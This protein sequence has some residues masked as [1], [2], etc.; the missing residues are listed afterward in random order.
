NLF[1][2]HSKPAA[3]LTSTSRLD[4]RVQRQQI[5]LIRDVIDQIQQPTNVLHPPC[6]RQ[7]PLT[8]RLDIGLGLL[9]IVTSLRGL[10]SN[11]INRVSNRHRR[12]RQ[13]LS[14]RRRLRHPS[15]LLRRRRRQLIR[16]SRQLRRR[17]IHLNADQ[18]CLVC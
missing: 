11:L 8:R 7:G 2:H 15:R 1:G 3:L 16:R 13:L 12:P 17:R 5:G 10:R 9:E 4:R 18:T 6:Q 14:R